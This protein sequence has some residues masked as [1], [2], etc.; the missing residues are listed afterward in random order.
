MFLSYQPRKIAGLEKRPK[1]LK[2]CIHR[3]FSLQS[4]LEFLNKVVH[5]M[6]LFMNKRGQTV[7]VRDVHCVLFCWVPESVC[8]TPDTI[9]ARYGH[10]SAQRS[11]NGEFSHPS[12][13]QGVEQGPVEALTTNRVGSSTRGDSIASPCS[14]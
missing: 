11:W 1:A 9:S 8:N 14:T 3:V 7:L 13:Y 6:L 5:G 12:F 10:T 4:V 2:L